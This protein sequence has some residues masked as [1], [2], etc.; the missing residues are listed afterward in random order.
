M[1][2]YADLMIFCSHFEMLL[3]T[4]S[5]KHPSSRRTCAVK[6]IHVVKSSKKA[7]DSLGLAVRLLEI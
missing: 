4:V 6:S 2:R 3:S 7:I 5:N 1:I